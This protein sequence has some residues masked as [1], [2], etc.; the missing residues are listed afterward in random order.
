MRRYKAADF[1]PFKD[2]VPVLSDADR[3]KH[4]DALRKA[5]QEAIDHSQRHIQGL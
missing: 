2:E 5:Y 4:G 1:V 3:K